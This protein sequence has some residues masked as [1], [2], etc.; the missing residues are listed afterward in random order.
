MPSTTSEPKANQF[1]IQISK[2][3]ITKSYNYWIHSTWIWPS[4][5]TD[6]AA[7]DRGFQRCWR[8][9]GSGRCVQKRGQDDRDYSNGEPPA[10]HWWWC[11]PTDIDLGSLRWHLVAPIVAWAAIMPWRG[12]VGGRS[13]TKG[14]GREVIDGGAEGG[15]WGRGMTMTRRGCNLRGRGGWQQGTKVE[16]LGLG[17]GWGL[18]IYSISD[19]RSIWWGMIWCNGWGEQG[20]GNVGPLL[21]QTLFRVVTVPD[22]CAEGA[23][24][25]WSDHRVGPARDTIPSVPGR[26]SVRLFRGVPMLAHQAWP[27]CTLFSSHCTPL[28][29]SLSLYM[30][31]IEDGLTPKAWQ[32]RWSLSPLDLDISTWAPRFKTLCLCFPP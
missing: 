19:Y 15:S 20:R 28:S 3:I 32:R 31:E 27:I 4:V 13:V 21:G 8:P 22:H 18:L 2:E 12:E 17:W 5:M 7:P 26:S 24:N 11:S 14:V 9:R 25:A 30:W 23:A 29:L 10:L 6:G 16:W 1:E